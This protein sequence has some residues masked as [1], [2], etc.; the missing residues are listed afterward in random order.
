[1]LSL[2]LPFCRQFRYLRQRIFSLASRQWKNLS[3][4]LQLLQYWTLFQELLLTACTSHIHPNTSKEIV[5][6]SNELRVG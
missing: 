1:M 6:S 5:A 3:S 2:V 4:L